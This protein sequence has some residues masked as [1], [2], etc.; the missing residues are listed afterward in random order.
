MHGNHTILITGATGTIGRPLVDLLVGEG[1]T[2]RAVTRNPLAAGLP[3][4]VEVVAGDPGRPATLAP[5]WRA[6]TPCSCTRA[7]PGTAPASC[8]RLPG[9]RG[10]SGWWRCRR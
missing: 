3:A 4:H 6:S 2:V 1:A 9:H 7:P 8:W 10:C 5:S